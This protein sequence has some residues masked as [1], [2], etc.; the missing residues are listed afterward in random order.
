MGGCVVNSNV[1]KAGNGLY[2]TF[3]L[4]NGTPMYFETDTVI[5]MLKNDTKKS[6]SKGVQ[7]N[8][9]L[10]YVGVL[11]EFL[12]DTYGRTVYVGWN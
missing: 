4:G 11:W 7:S 1:I 3:P 10:L 6:V 2:V 8:M 9:I 5:Y 12:Y